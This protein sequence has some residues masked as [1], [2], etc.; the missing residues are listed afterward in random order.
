MFLTL[1]DPR[2]K[3]QGSRD[4]LGLQP[5]WTHFGREVVTN[6][7]TVSRAVR[8]FAVTL[9]GRYFG[10]ML[11]DEGR[12]SEEDVVPIFLRLEQVAAYARY[13]RAND[14]QYDIVLGVTRVARFLNEHHGKVPIRNNATGF[15]L[16]DQKTYGLWGLYSVSARESG[17]LA[18]GPVGLTPWAREF[19]EREYLPRLRPAQGKLVKLILEGGPLDTRNGR[20]PFEA[21]AK[22]LSGKLTANERTFYGESLRDA[23]KVKQRPSAAQRQRQLASL[24]TTHCAPDQRFGREDVV[25]LARAAAKS[26]VTSLAQRLDWILRIEA[27]LAPAESLFELLQSRNGQTPATVARQLK[28]P[29]GSRIPNLSTPLEPLLAEVRLAVSDQ[30]ARHL[31]RCDDALSTGDYLEAIM[32]ILDWN[33]EVMAARGSAAWVKLTKGKLDVRYRSSETELPEGKELAELWRNTYFVDTLRDVAFQLE[34]T[35]NGR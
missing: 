31:G 30:Q 23:L 7:T 12:A 16:S 1:E 4:P 26:D 27:L 10:E 13:L 18:D 19:V 22:I 20:Q 29:W 17:L 21:M 28:K 15:I 2:A 25:K 24:I 6:L 35:E 34:T 33:Q 9:L 32:A 3:V 11:L 5:I 8:G 14:E